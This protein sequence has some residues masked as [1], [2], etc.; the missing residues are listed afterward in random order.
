MKPS[1]DSAPAPSPA[2][3]LRRRRG[4][5]R[6]EKRRKPS[7]P[8]STRL[9]RCNSFVDLEN[10][11]PEAKPKPLWLIGQGL[12]PSLP[13]N[14]RSSSP[15]RR[16][17]EIKPDPPSSY[18]I[19]STE[20]AVFRLLAGPVRRQLLLYN[21]PNSAAAS[22][23]TPPRRR[24]RK[25]KSGARTPRTETRAPRSI[26]GQ[27][28][29]HLAGESSGADLFEAAV[30]GAGTTTPDSRSPTATRPKPTAI[31]SPHA[32][33]GGPP[34]LRRPRG[35]QKERSRQRSTPESESLEAKS[36]RLSL[37][38]DGKG[39]AKRPTAKYLVAQ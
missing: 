24:S 38:S 5:H 14:S 37:L 1:G 31:H 33:S 39:R 29:E 21:L 7:D 13:S 22:E 11:S 2:V 8:S 12:A 30:A 34:P 35:R 28:E 3:H 36:S 32:R 19:P 15:R 16:R 25:T 26:A 4:D 23:H 17:R 27:G 9:H 6:S 10:G 18:R 20:L